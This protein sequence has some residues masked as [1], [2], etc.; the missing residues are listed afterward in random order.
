[1][2]ATYDYILVRISNTTLIAHN[3]KIGI[4][5]ILNISGKLYHFSRFITTIIIKTKNKIAI[6]VN[7]M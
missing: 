6:I 3:T 4:T 5:A 7:R 2:E 1:M